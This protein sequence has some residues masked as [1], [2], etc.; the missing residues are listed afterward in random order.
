MSFNHA[1]PLPELPATEAHRRV[2]DGAQLVDVRELP[3]FAQGHAPDA[4]NLP[5]SKL[6]LRHGDLDP[7]R[8][9]AVLC[10]SGNRSAMAVQYL[11]QLGFDAVN[12]SGGMIAWE[13]S[14]LP[15]GAPERARTA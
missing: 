8:P 14:G 3:E 11:R 2:R 7:G 9:V 13:R 6:A 15:V 5:L 4:I 12:V 10:R 1:S